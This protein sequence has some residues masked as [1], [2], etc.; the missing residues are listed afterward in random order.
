MN[1]GTNPCY[2]VHNKYTDD[3]IIILCQEVPRNWIVDI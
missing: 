3:E 2:T 1:N